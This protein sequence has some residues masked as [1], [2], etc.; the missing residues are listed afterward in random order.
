MTIGFTFA[1]IKLAGTMY[2][3]TQRHPRG[4]EEVSEI[5]NRITQN[6]MTSQGPRAPM[7]THNC[8]TTHGFEEILAKLSR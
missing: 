3:C 6:L 2:N 5:L 4:D 8:Y 1:A 7:G